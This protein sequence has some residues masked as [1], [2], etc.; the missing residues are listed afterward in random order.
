MSEVL[1]LLLV[2]LVLARMM[3]KGLGLDFTPL[4][5]CSHCS[6]L[7]GV[8]VPL[9]SVLQLGCFSLTFAGCE[10]Q[11][12]AARANMRVE[13]LQAKPSSGKGRGGVGRGSPSPRLVLFEHCLAHFFYFS[14][15]EV[16][17]SF[18]SLSCSLSTTSNQM[19]SRDK[20][21]KT[22]CLY[23]AGCQVCMPSKYLRQKSLNRQYLF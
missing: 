20:T 14:K 12:W 5:W 16:S 9:L 17:L 6:L 23:L 4:A 11:P 1:A 3:G 22:Q 7:R 13:G 21:I 2:S 18:Y 15:H 8:M 10:L 19:G